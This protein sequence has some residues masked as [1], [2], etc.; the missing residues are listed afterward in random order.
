[1]ERYVFAEHRRYI[2]HY[3]NGKCVGQYR[4]VKPKRSYFID[5]NGEQ[6]EYGYCK[7]LGTFPQDYELFVVYDGIPYLASQD[8]WNMLNEEL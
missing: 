4:R 7:I 5:G 2:Y 8:V 6:V 1:M 3:V